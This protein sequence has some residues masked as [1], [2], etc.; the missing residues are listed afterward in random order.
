MAER[1]PRMSEQCRAAPLEVLDLKKLPPLG[2]P[3]H[4]GL[5]LV[6]APMGVGQ[7]TPAG[8]PRQDPP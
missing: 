2:R 8:E 1:M 6:D 3:L 7:L 5:L 4:H